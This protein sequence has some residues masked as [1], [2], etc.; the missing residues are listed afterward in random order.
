MKV[1]VV[2]AENSEVPGKVMEVF[3][4]EHYAE[5]E[6]RNL[7]AMVLDTLRL[8]TLASRVRSTVMPYSWRKALVEA[9]RYRQDEHFYVDLTPHDVI[10]TE[11]TTPVPDLT[12]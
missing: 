10:G 11:E 2:E 5:A 9:E 1:Y 7:T 6:A 8:T 3:A 12:G 4:H